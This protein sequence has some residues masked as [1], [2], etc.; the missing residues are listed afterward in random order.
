VLTQASSRFYK[1]EQA[2]ENNNYVHNRAFYSGK[3]VDTILE[4]MVVE[5]IAVHGRIMAVLQGREPYAR[6]W[7]DFAMGFITLHKVNK[8]YK[9]QELGLGESDPLETVFGNTTS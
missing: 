6:V 2:G 1:E 7:L 5:D 9:L 8:R 4:E 3:D